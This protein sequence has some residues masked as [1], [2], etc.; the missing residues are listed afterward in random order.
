[1][2]CRL[3]MFSRLPRRF[4]RI[5]QIDAEAE[6]LIAYFGS[7]A[8]SEARQRQLQASS[9]A[10]AEDWSRVARAVARKTKAQSSLTANEWLTNLWLRF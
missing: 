2:V 5:E 1:M 6:A 9:D 7:A 3:A 8:Y 4:A 10:I